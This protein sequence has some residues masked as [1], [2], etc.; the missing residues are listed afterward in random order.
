ME[1]SIN[2]DAT[3]AS[4]MQADNLD[5]AAAAE[6]LQVSAVTIWRLLNGRQFPSRGLAQRIALASGG[7][8]SLEGIAFEGDKKGAA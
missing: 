5:N 8:V 3:L 7:R 6:K 1:N 4:W 2:T